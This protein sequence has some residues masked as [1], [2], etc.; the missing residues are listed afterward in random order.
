MVPHH[1]DSGQLGRRCDAKVV[2]EVRQSVTA[3]LES[4]ELF[5][6][7]A[8]VSPRRMQL[9]VDAHLAQ[10]TSQFSNLLAQLQDGTL[11]CLQR[12]FELDAL[13]DLFTALLFPGGGAPWSES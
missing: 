9:L 7:L 10:R 11:S 4:V 13:L 12:M 8:G 5:V 1:P 3:L 2:Y 6:V